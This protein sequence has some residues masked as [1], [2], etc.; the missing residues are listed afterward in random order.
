MGGK[1]YCTLYPNN[2]KKKKRK[3]VGPHHFLQTGLL[4]FFNF[5]LVLNCPWGKGP[6]RAQFGGWWKA[7]P[8]L[9]TPPQH[10]PESCHAPWELGRERSFILQGSEVLIAKA[11]AVNVPGWGGR[12][13][14]RKD[15]SP[16]LWSCHL[17]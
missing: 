10:T 7:L 1:G 2:L 13:L 15:N 11:M 12:Q 5:F 9:P 4:E 16:L 17:T 14:G 6:R 3:K 8:P